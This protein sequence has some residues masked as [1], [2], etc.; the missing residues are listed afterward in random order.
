MAAQK[1]MGQLLRNLAIA[2]AQDAAAVVPDDGDDLGTTPCR[3]LYV[4]VSGDVKVTTSD[5]TTVTFKAA[6][7]GI[8]AVSVKRVFATGTT[9]TNILALY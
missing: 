3:A 6:P 5:G 7:V 8:L 4:G 2:P 1:W 9:A